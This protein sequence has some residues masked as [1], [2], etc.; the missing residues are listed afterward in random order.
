MLNDGAQPPA[1]HRE[2]S[3]VRYDKSTRNWRRED[4]NRVA[5]RETVDASCVGS[6]AGAS[7]VGS[8]RKRARG[9]SPQSPRATLT[10]S[11]SWQPSPSLMVRTIDDAAIAAI[12]VKRDK[13]RHNTRWRHSP[14]RPCQRRFSA[15]SWA[16]HTRPSR[17]HPLQWPGDED[18]AAEPDQFVTTTKTNTARG[19]QL[20]CDVEDLI[21]PNQERHGSS[22]HP[23]N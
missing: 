4:D 13:R 1:E 11:P 17:F 21:H 5:D 10:S 22:R 19:E 3:S 20:N 8:P 12:F 15:C 9:N 7:S 6:P 16:G 18:Q 23:P 14:W 2:G